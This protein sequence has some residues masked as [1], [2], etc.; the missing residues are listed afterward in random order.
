MFK[1]NL[2]SI[3]QMGESDEET[4]VPEAVP[5]EPEP[6]AMD[7]DIWASEEEKAA[8]RALQ[9]KTSVIG[10]TAAFTGDLAAK[11]PVVVKGSVEGNIS[12]E[13]KVTIA[14]TVTG[15]ITGKSVQVEAGGR[16]RGNIAASDDLRLEAGASVEGDLAGREIGLE[17]ALA[18]NVS[19][20]GSL[21]LGPGSTVTG[22]IST[23]D[24]TT[25]LGARV[26]GRVEMQE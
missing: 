20:S 18:G 16:V 24:L 26:N 12:C 8:K 6:V 17:G 4:A 1:K 10:E 21:T 2:G 7:E 5:A 3:I 19:C 22:D 11:G 25:A 15:N 13:D 14:G 23:K 9:E